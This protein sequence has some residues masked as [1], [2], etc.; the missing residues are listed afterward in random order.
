[1]IVH[2][3]HLQLKSCVSACNFLMSERTIDPK[4]LRSISYTAVLCS[5]NYQIMINQIMSSPSVTGIAEARYT[6]Y[7][8]Q[9]F[10]RNVISRRTPRMQEPGRDKVFESILTYEAS[11]STPFDMPYTAV[12]RVSRYQN[13]NHPPTAIHAKAVQLYSCN[14]IQLYIRSIPCRGYSLAEDR[15]AGGRPH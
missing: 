14:R 11:R 8:V 10:R 3:L 13:H 6:G 4:I 9:N 15:T 7:I 12:R 5:I 2:G 1:M